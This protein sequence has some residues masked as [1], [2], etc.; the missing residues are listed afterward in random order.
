M[1]FIIQNRIGI[2]VL[3]LPEV[4]HQWQRITPLS[5]K[6][7]CRSDGEDQAFDN[8]C[9]TKIKVLANDIGQFVV[10]QFSCAVAVIMIEVG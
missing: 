3:I 1:C 7:V 10:G 5:S 4:S 9:R 2:S 8:S 6:S